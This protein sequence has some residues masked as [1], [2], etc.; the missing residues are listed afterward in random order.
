MGKD[1]TIFICED[2]ETREIITKK[3]FEKDKVTY[4]ALLPACLREEIIKGVE[5]IED[6]YEKRN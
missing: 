2:E 3:Y 6:E 1:I 5:K 4:C